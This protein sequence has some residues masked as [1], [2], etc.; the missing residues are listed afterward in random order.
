MS[1]VN[2]LKLVTSVSEL[3][4]TSEQIEARRE[5]AKK[6]RK[7]KKLYFSY[8]PIEDIPL[9]AQVPKSALY[10]KVYQKGGW[11]EERT[12]SEKSEAK[13]IAKNLYGKNFQTASDLIEIIWKGVQK[14]AAEWEERPPNILELDMISRIYSR[15]HNVMCLEQAKLHPEDIE[16]LRPEE[17]IKTLMQ[18]PFRET[19]ISK[20]ML[21]PPEHPSTEPE[22]IDE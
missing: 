16:S 7:A 14:A 17:V 6:I 3:K 2:E 12:K 20:G 10:T 13:K 18:N 19:A 5:R 9:L 11:L 1:E 15:I 22:V 4:E 8:T 21:P